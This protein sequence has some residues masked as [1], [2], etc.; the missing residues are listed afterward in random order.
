MAWRVCRLVSSSSLSSGSWKS[1]GRRL[2][3]PL[4]TDAVLNAS[5][6]DYPSALRHSS[7][8]QQ[9]RSVLRTT[10]LLCAQQHWKAATVTTTSTTTTAVSTQRRSFSSTETFVPQSPNE[11]SSAMA[12]G[13]LD[14]T[15]FYIRHGIS[16]QRLRALANQSEMPVMDKWQQMM[17]IYITTQLHVIAGLGYPATQDGLNLYAQHLHAC[18]QSVTDEAMRQLFVEVR[19]DTWREIVAIVFDVPLSELP[20]L[21]IVEARNLMHQVSSKMMA[22]DT[23]LMIQ[24]QTAK[25][26]HDDLAVEIQQKHGILQTILVNHVYLG[27]HNDDGLSLVER[28]GFGTGP[29]GYAK[30]QCALSDHEGDPLMADYAASAMMKLLTA[31]GIDIDSIQGPGLGASAV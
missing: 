19:R 14:S 22:P 8:Q 25:I 5:S 20:V 7:E 15:Q 11:L 26:C 23:L 31:A 2:A 9:L 30:L 29:V 1:P 6:H 24:Q 28:A 21:T 16:N 18:L 3:Q 17:E 10:L 4:C 27:V 13:I 12:E